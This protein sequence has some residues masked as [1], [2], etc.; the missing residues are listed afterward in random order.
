MDQAFWYSIDNGLTSEQQYP[1]TTESKK[2]YYSKTMKVVSVGS[3]A[4]VPS[5]NYSKMISAVTQ[6]PVSVAIDARELKSYKG[7]VFDGECG[8]KINQGMLLVGFGAHHD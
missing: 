4:V 2:C 5:G 6:Q 8:E 3:C 1:Y 7:G